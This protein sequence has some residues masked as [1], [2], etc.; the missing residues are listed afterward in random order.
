MAKVID[1]G[2]TVYE[3][4]KEDPQIIE[5]MRELG[6]E[7]ITNTA[8]LNTVGRFMTI[9]KGAVIKKIDLEKIKEEFIKKGYSI[10]E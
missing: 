7:Q 3:L 1:F 9:P 5:I 4:C 8:S 6:F 2:K 10:I